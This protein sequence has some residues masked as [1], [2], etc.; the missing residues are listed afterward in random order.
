[1]HITKK[2][3]VIFAIVLLLPILSGCVNVAQTMAF[4]EDGSGKLSVEMSIDQALLQSYQDDYDYTEDPFDSI[5]NSAGTVDNV[6]IT[7]ISN[8]SV[9]G[10]KIETDFTGPEDLMPAFTRISNAMSETEATTESDGNYTF[11][12]NKSILKTTWVFKGQLD[13]TQNE[14]ENNETTVETG[15]FSEDEP[16][17]DE[18]NDTFG[19]VATSAI[20][21][22]MNIEVR[23]IMPGSIISTNGTI[24]N[25]G[26][27]NNKVIWD[28]NELQKQETIE[29]V[30]EKTNTVLLIAI[31]GGILLLIVGIGAT[32]TVVLLKKS[33][34]KKE[35]NLTQHNGQ[36]TQFNNQNNIP[37]FNNQEIPNVQNNSF[38]NSILNMTPEQKSKVAVII[39]TNSHLDGMGIL[40]IKGTQSFE[41]ENGQ[42]I[43]LE[44]MRDLS[45]KN[46]LQRV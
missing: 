13:N 14:T 29:A 46:M 43:T 35:L 23:V 5:K 3:I 6:T 2:V 10:I 45:L 11:E 21:D 25:Q 28:L 36:N 7:D 44:Q 18:F 26:T 27:D 34:K 17:I 38:E 37:N 20:E 33:K 8:D 42:P 16:A 19:D 4:N 32:V 40:N 22:M 9:S 24:S 15:T 1:M 39:N 30:S 41:L 31:G 12:I